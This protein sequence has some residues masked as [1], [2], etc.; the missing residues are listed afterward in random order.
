M[1]GV[2]R[3][4]PGS[5]QPPPPPPHHPPSSPVPVTSTPV[6]PPIRR[7]LAFA[8][9]KPPFHPS[10]DYHRFNPSSLSNNNDRSFVHGCGVVDR[11]EDAVVVRSPSRKRKATM[12]MVVAPSNNGFT[13]SGF[14]NIPSSP[15]Q[16]PRKGGRVNIKSKA[17]GNKSTPQTP[18]STNAGS[19]ITLTPSGSCRYDSS[20]GLLTKKFV[21]L[22]KQA[23][24][25]MLDLNKAA[26]TLEVQKR[27]IY[28]ITNVLEGI[29]LIE[30]PF[31]N[32]I[33][34]KGVDACPGDEDADVS[35]LQAEI[36]NLALEE[37]ALDNQIRQ[38]EERLR[39]LSE[40]EKN[41]KWLFVT[42]E[43]IKSLP[44]FQNQTLIAVK[45]PHGTTL[46][47]PDPDEAA[48]HPQRRYRII[49]RSTMGPIDVYLVSEFEGKFEDTNGS[50]AAPPA[51]LPI[52]S[53]SGSTGHHDIE[54]LTVDNPETAIVS[55][56]HPHPQPGDTSD[57]N[58]LQEQVGGMLKITPSDVENDESDYWLLSNAEISM[59]DIWKTDSGI[60]WDYGIADVSTPPPGMG[61]IAPTAVDSTPR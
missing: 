35:V 7:H 46:E 44:G 6:I 21:N 19:P 12:D 42:E 32:R 55:H 45:A 40:N 9:T 27:R 4:S 10:D 8:S 30:K 17:K 29:D 22:I 26:E 58:Y 13:S 23:K 33:L 15:C 51:C 11:E 5:S 56:D 20:L 52:A 2:V 61:E 24:D 43:D 49:L 1:S 48:D 25:G 3:S 31:K 34:W 57:L 60:D 38:T 28:D 54:A 37:Q 18:I 16:T 50:G 41:Q 14:T 39:D 47:V 53:S 36:E 59:T